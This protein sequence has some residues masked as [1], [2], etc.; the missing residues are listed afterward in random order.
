MTPRSATPAATTLPA[1]RT[2]YLTRVAAFACAAVLT[3][4]APLADA[5]GP[6]GHAIVADIAQQHL[7][8]AAAAQVRTLLGV[9]GLQ[10]LD[11][12]SSWADGNRK[13]RPHT[14]SWH[15][16]DIPLHANSYVP[17]RD[18]ARNNCV[19]AQISHFAQV[20][21]D[22]SAAPAARLEALKWVVHF[23][24]DVH[25]PLHAEDDD[26]KGGNTVQ[27]QFFG[28]GSNLHAVWDGG[29]LRHALGLVPGPN[30]SFDHAA[31]QAAAM[32]LDE[33]ISPA[34]RT[35]WSAIG[36][37]PALYHQTVSWAGESHTLARDVAYAHLD[38]RN[39]AGWSQRY[40]DLAW[41]VTRTRLQQGG[42]RL[43]AVLNELLGG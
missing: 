4:C 6:E 12:I 31:V 22:R 26:D 16:V 10:R 35:A 11:Q 24:G 8:P 41:P 43:A 7:D 15:Y 38:G 18:C 42:V 39:Q 9:E 23:V 30:Y 34:D 25:Q 40:Q 32:R 33:A 19:I 28:R 20:L 14:G 36:G 37:L 29:V 13:E 3:L 21:A 17:A 5:W 2:R 27:V 1:R